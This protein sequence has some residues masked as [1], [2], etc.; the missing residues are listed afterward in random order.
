MSIS[1]EHTGLKAG[2][3]QTDRPT[4]RQTDRRTDRPTDGQ[5]TADRRTERERERERE[6]E[7]A[8]AACSLLVSLKSGRTLIEKAGLSPQKTLFAEK[9]FH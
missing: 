5:R 3:R 2:V 9:E 8:L 7:F 6:R 1:S 4:D